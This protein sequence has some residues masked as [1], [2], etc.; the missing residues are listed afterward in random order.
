MGSSIEPEPKPPAADTGGPATAQRPV[1]LS[2]R[3]IRRLADL[4]RRHALVRRAVV[5]VLALGIAALVWV[6]PVTEHHSDGAATL[7]A[8]QALPDFGT[9]A[10]AAQNLLSAPICA[11][12]FLALYFALRTVVGW[13]EALIIAGVSVLGSSLVSTLAAGL[14]SSGFAILLLTV[15]LADTARR[16][17]PGPQRPALP[18]RS[19]AFVLLLVGVAILCRPTAVFFVAGLLALILAEARSLRLALLTLV[20]LRLSTLALALLVEHAGGLLSDD[21]PLRLFLTEATIGDGLYGVLL[22]PSRGLLVFSPF[23]LVVVFAITVALPRLVRSSLFWL[24]GTWIAFH[25][26]AVATREVWWGGHSYGPRLLAETIPP[27]ALLTGLVWRDWRPS[28]SVRRRAL[29]AYLTLALVGVAIHSGQGLF[30]E[31][32]KSWNEIPNVDRHPELLFSWRYP[33]FLATERLVARRFIDHVVDGLAPHP[34]GVPLAFDAERAVFENWYPA[35]EAWR[36]SKRQST[37]HFVLSHVEPARLHLLELDLSAPVPQS[38]DVI[39]N[40]ANLGTLHLGSPESRQRVL[41]LPGTL[42]ESPGRNRLTLRAAQAL[43]IGADER[44]L[45]V[46]FRSLLLRPLGPAF[47][48]VRF[49]DEAYFGRGWSRDRNGVRWTSERVATLVYPLGATPR[50]KD[51][52]VLLETGA[53]DSQTVEVLINDQSVATTVISGQEPR[54]VVFSVAMETLR[55]RSLNRVELRIPGARPV[56]EDPRHLGIDFVRLHIRARAADLPD[57]VRRDE[58]TR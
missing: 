36:W 52:E 49:D 53:L 26:L 54:P 39:V 5:L 46:A 40:G 32:V 24:C 16:A 41:A 58:P 8:D 34:L 18:P 37:I 20:V 42:L 35:E 51:W 14:W 2:G 19:L 3:G 9:R 12:V 50:S 25:V 33:Q 43:S 56:G 17:R 21:D 10:L 47:P 22:S 23:L 29:A 44:R 31:Q 27:L 55:A 6:S 11:A 38:V 4:G 28:P 45:G 57:G 13:L 30:N 15:A 1:G 48:G 7:L